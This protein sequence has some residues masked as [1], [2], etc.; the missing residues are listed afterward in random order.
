MLSYKVRVTVGND[1]SK[2]EKHY[3]QLLRHLLQT[4]RVQ[5]KEEQLTQLLSESES[6]VTQS[7]PTLCDPMDCSLPGFFVHGIFLA[8]VL[9]WVAISYSRGP[10]P[11]GDGNSISCYKVK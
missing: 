5:V 6:E 7:C 2:A 9:E 1:L 10:S 8:R 4:A 11:P 3:L